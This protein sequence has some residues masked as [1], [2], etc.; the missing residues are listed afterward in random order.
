MLS[1]EP[2][3]DLDAVSAICADPYVARAGHD[4]RPVAA[5]DHPN[6]HYL[7]AYVEG[8]LVGAFLV[9]ESGWIELD[10]HALL[11]RKALAWCRELGRLCIAWCFGHPMVQRVTAQVIEGLEAARNYCR[12]LGFVDEGFRRDAAMVGGELR[13]VYVLGLTRRQWG[14]A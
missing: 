7:G 9:I 2:L 11:T 13:G 10:L 12:R 6:A 8:S 14:E 4:H 1:V 3:S 5:I